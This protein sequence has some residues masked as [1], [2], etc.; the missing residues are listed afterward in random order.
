MFEEVNMKN[1]YLIRHGKPDFAGDERYCI[2]ITDLPL[3]KIG[4]EQALLL[5]KF[6]EGKSIE[7]YYSSP[8]LR[9]RQTAEL[10]AP[11]R[12]TVFAVNGFREIDMGDWEGMPF[13]KI[14]QLYP[15]D[16]EKRGQDMA[17]YSS[18]GGES[19][20]QC[21]R[22]A[23]TAFSEIAEKITGNIAIVAHAGIN[24][25]LLCR[26]TGRPLS[27]MMTIE[28]PYGCVNIIEVTE[29]MPI[30][31]NVEKIAHQP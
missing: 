10:I 20:E 21:A 26:L 4:K 27:E 5:Q 7:H 17:N 16:Y 8:L 25:A 12:E 23:W 15:E 3:A 14:K 29:G 11:E 2:G 9:C 24:R 13:E 6:F 22:R 28:Q 31:Y 19:F 1:I 30:H 18:P